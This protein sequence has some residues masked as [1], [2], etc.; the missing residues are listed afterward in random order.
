[1]PFQRRL[2]KR[3]FNNI[4]KKKYAIVNVQDFVKFE[5]GSKIDFEFLKKAGVLKKRFDGLKVLGLGDLNKNFHVIADKFSKSAKQ[6]IE[7]AK[8]KAE[9]K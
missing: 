4:F 5:A 6:K 8:G 1:M 9:V 2:P 3:G 7:I